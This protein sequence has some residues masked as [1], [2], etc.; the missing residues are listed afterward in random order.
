[1]QA[2]GSNQIMTNVNPLQADKFQ[3]KNHHHESTNSGK[4]EKGQGGLNNPFF[5][6]AFVIGV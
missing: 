2:F 6:R 1:M 5:F 4:H 3:I